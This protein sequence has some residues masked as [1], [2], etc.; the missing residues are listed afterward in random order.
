MKQNIRANQTGHATTNILGIHTLADGYNEANLRTPMLPVNRYVKKIEYFVD[1]GPGQTIVD[2]GCGDGAV[3]AILAETYPEAFFYG[4]DYSEE[5]IEYAKRNNSRSNIEYRVANLNAENISTANASVD[6]IFSWG[7]MYYV[8]PKNEYDIFQKEFLR[9]L[10]TPGRICHF[11]IPLRF[12]GYTLNNIYQRK[13]GIAARIRRMR[14]HFVDLFSAMYNEYTYKYSMS[15][16]LRMQSDFL[17]IKIIPD[18]FFEDR[19]SVIY[20]R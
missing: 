8:H 9:V 18:D 17:S 16:L 13:N 15:D 20:D 2:F 1:I 12:A 3:T 5:L 14:L 11:Q 10:K 7:V 4:I 19:I 6:R